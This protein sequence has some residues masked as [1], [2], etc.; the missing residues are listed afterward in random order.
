MLRYFAYRYSKLYRGIEYPCAIQVQVESMHIGKISGLF[1]ILKRQNFSVLGVLQAEQPGYRKVDI[2]QLDHRGRLLKVD[3]AVLLKIY[4]LRLNASKHRCAAAF[5]HVG[6]GALTD[7]VFV[8]TFAVAEQRAE[9]CLRTARA[10]ERGFLAQHLG[11]QF[12]Q[13][14]NGWVFPMHVVPHLGIRHGLAHLRCRSSNGVA[15]KIDGHD[16]FP[17]RR[18]RE[19]Y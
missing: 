15:A 13:T 1:K 9:I 6:V 12:L 16:Q 14:I 11:S 19:R 8:A 3:S 17:S 18:S 10:K 7:D 4:G 2:V 5:K